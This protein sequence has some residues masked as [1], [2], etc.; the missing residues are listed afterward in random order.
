SLL[1]NRPDVIAA[2][3]N[4]VRNFELTNVARSN[5]YPS[6]RLTAT[7]GL[8]SVDLK[9]WFSANSLFANVVTGLTQPVF[10]QRQIRTRYE[11]AKAEQEIAYLQF[12]QSLLNA[13]RE[14]S[15]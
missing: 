3:Y 4:L 8:Q 1:S 2:E 12:E 6:L 5:F 9:D 14:V 13:G 10:N 15:D 7:G 11:I